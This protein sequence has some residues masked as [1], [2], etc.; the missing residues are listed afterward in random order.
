MKMHLYKFCYFSF[1]H[2]MWLL[3]TLV[4]SICLPIPKIM[5]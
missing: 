2:L 4:L 5:K 1:L 3:G